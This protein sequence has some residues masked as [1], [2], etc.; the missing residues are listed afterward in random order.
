[1]ERETAPPPGSLIGRTDSVSNRP[2]ADRLRRSSTHTR[3]P[4]CSKTH[5]RRFAS[6]DRSEVLL[7]S[8]A[9]P[10]QAQSTPGSRPHLFCT[11]HRTSRPA[12]RFAAATL[13]L[14]LHVRELS[15]AASIA[16]MLAAS[17]AA[18]VA[19]Y[20]VAEAAS[21]PPSVFPQFPPVPPQP[22]SHP[23]CCLDCK[24]AGRLCS[25]GQLGGAGRE[26]GASS[27]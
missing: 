4:D 22:P 10:Q 27:R 19:P 23:R 25:C 11:N 1:M 20:D 12:L 2:T 8:H 6:S 15:V 7:A 17:T 3:D 16:G 21:P 5:R 24:G 26:P 18:A 14:F 13:T 9:A